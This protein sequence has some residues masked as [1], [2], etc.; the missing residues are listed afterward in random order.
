MIKFIEETLK[1]GLKVLIHQDASTPLSALNLLYD[2]GSRDDPVEHTG[3]AHFFEHLMFTGTESTPDFDVPLYK[4]SGDNNAFTNTDTTNYHITIPDVNLNV[5]LWL[6]ADRMSNLKLSQKQIDIQRKVVIEE[7]HET[8]LNQP[9]GTA[10]HYI[11]KACYQSHPYH[12]PTIGLNTEQIA[13]IGSLDV[14]EF[15]EKF[16][17]PGNCILAISSPE[18]PMLVMDTVRSYFEPI[19]GRIL[20]SRSK[21]QVLH[22]FATSRQ[23]IQEDSV[24]SDQLYIC[25][26]VPGRKDDQFYAADLLT[27]ILAEGTSSR[28]YRDL[29]KDRKIASSIDCYTTA[30]IEEGL[31]IIEA[32]PSEQ[33]SLEELEHAIYSHIDQLC[34]QLTDQEEL[35]K[36]LV[37]METSNAFTDTSI[38]NKVINLSYY[39]LLDHPEWINEEIDYYKRSTP[40]EIKLMANKVFKDGPSF[41]LVYKK[42]ED[43]I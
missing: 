17:Q 20:N 15:Y 12:W 32:R 9:Y 38:L 22:K 11:S 6:E 39:K 29:V 27:D 37:K 36:I 8:T 40:V 10:W 33:S 30:T 41:T 28:L 23:V 34:E 18:D 24:P 35:D 19:P 25:F 26:L 2:V 43:I 7:F 1:N 16:Y 14:Q 42:N 3:M 31:L 21:V 13:S 4:A 5:A